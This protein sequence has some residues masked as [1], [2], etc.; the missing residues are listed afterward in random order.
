MFFR[1]KL[2]DNA[3]GKPTLRSKTE[4]SKKQ[5]MAM[6]QVAAMTIVALKRRPDSQP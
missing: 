4:Q 2:S 6:T 5:P 3:P 1:A